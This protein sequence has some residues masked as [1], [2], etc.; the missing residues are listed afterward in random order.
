MDAVL[1]AQVV[2]NAIMYVYFL[3]LVTIGERTPGNVD[4]VFG[5]LVHSE[6]KGL[7]RVLQCPAHLKT[8][9]YRLYFSVAKQRK[10]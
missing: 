10:R 5:V 1:R 4:M 8:A 3:E 2:L 7:S 6:H 9:R